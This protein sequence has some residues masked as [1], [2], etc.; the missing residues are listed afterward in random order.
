MSL[1]SLAGTATTSISALPSEVALVA[2][3]QTNSLKVS[4]HDAVSA[5]SSEARRKPLS[6]KRYS[7]FCLFWLSEKASAPQAVWGAL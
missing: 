5:R 2:A 4:L 1:L 7:P 6:L 3:Q